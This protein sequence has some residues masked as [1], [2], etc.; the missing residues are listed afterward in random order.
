MILTV[1]ITTLLSLDGHIKLLFSGVAF[2]RIFWPSR[3]STGMTQDL[4]TLLLHDY[5]FVLLELA[6]FVF[7]YTYRNTS[8]GEKVKAGR[9]AL[10]VSILAGPMAGL[11]VIWA[12]QELKKGIS[13]PK[14]KMLD[15]DERTPLIQDDEN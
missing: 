10:L 8:K 2:K 4:H 7:L 1:G 15:R 5:T 12:M 9:L 11:S 6:S 13:E 3:T 14:D